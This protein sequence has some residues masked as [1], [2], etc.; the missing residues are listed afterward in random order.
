[1]AA[2]TAKRV[3]DAFSASHALGTRTWGEGA[4]ESAVPAVDRPAKEMLL[5]YL[6]M[7]APAVGA[8]RTF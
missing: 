2:T 6:D 3:F 7:H 1:M 8:N 4:A 5:H